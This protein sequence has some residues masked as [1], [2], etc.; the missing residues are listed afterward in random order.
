MSKKNKT[1]KTKKPVST[2][3]ADERSH[4]V[5]K[6]SVVS[7]KQSFLISFD[8][9]TKIF[10]GV[11]IGAYVIL[12]LLKIHTSNIGSWDLFFGKPESESVIAG[13]PRFIRM[14]EWCINTPGA[15]SQYQ[16]G[17]PVSNPGLGAEHTPVV[18]GLPVKDISTLLRPNHWSYFLFDE[19]R[20]F[21]FSWNFYI[22]FSIIS[23]FLLFKLL[24]RNSFWLA[25]FGSFFIFFSSGVQWWSYQI[26]FQ[27]MYLSC[28]LIS[29]IYILYSKLFWS[30]I[31]AGIFFLLGVAGFLFV[32]Y[33]AFQ[34]PLIYLYLA[35]FIGLLWQRKNFK[36]ITEKLFIRISV[37]AG[38]LI[39]L[40]L[41]LYHYYYLVKDTYA[42]M[43]N[44]VYPGKRFSTGGNLINGKFFADFFGL[45]MT[46]TRFPKQW[47]NICEISGFIMVFPIIFYAIGYHYFKVKKIDPLLL[48]LSFFVIIGSV[49]VLL[50]FP[51]ILSKITFLSMSPSYRALPVLGAGNA[52]LLICY[53][54][55]RQTGQPQTK[56]SWIEFG[57]LTV[58]IIV[59]I[60]IVAI[61][62]NNVTDNFFTST[63]INIITLLLTIAYL[64]IRYKYLR[65]A[66]PVLYVVLG[67]MLFQN[68]LANPV[69][70]GLSAIRENPLV[71][72]S[73]E[74]HDADPQ[75]RWA[76]LGKE[77]WE[78]ARL[79]QLL[80]ANGING[81]NGV[82]FVPPI[83]DMRVLDPSGQY[84]SVYNRYAWVTMQT[85]IDRNDTVVIRQSFND[86][87]TIFLDPCSERLKQ[88][89]IKYL[90]FIYK[91][92]DEEVRCMTKVGEISNLYIYKRNDE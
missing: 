73:K 35:I 74:I 44:T 85:Y 72:T 31:L 66:K 26:G 8:R 49:Y 15:L 91:P 30:L 57:I 54:G 56:F 39:I 29:F 4:T 7:P 83:K 78:G 14:D 10:L 34:I 9:R 36:L 62:T 5:H 40:S 38:V 19:E 79:A 81:F 53:L 58:V 63:Q 23:L 3:G 65:F 76:V 17:M 82:K 13:K 80:V 2:R 75:A 28:V 22:F 50:G 32:L 43:M 52:V 87:Y 41:F 6:T 21:A 42:V 88:L 64:A 67:I 70:S 89:G 27:M 51:A 68:L 33:P 86:G 90:M 46:D 37:F 48:S 84:D 25:V 12:S 92:Q 20:A 18:L 69:T 24:T 61:H 60:R 77:G 11:L 47:L 45:F 59:F 16:S 55:S 71:K 1:R